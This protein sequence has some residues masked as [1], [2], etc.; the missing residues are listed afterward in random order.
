MCQLNAAV[1]PSRHG[2]IAPGSLLLRK[3]IPPNFDC[4]LLGA[5]PLP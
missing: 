4:L 3:P 5:L 2:A 1:G